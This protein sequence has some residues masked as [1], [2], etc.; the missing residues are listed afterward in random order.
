MK[1]YRKKLNNA[2]SIKIIINLELNAFIL[3]KYVQLKFMTFLFF[4]IYLQFF[5]TL[6]PLIS[7]TIVLRLLKKSI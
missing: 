4:L 3:S 6:I 1:E 7:G 2:N 5:F